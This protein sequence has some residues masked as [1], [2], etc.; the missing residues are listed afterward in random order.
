M[1]QN[2]INVKTAAEFNTI[3]KENQSILVTFF[4]KRSLTYGCETLPYVKTLSEIYTNTQFLIVDL[5]AH[6]LSSVFN[7]VKIFGFPL[8]KLY[9]VNGQSKEMYSGWKEIEKV[10]DEIRK[11]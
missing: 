1:S 3:L 6:D 2:C 5:E 9:N 8:F 7:D 11:I 4:Y 10:E